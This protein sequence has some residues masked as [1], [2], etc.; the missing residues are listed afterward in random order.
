MNNE[1]MWNIFLGGLSRTAKTHY[2]LRR[3]CSKCDKPIIDVSRFG[4]CRGCKVKERTYKKGESREHK[5]LKLLAKHFLRE[6]GFNEI[7]EEYLIDQKRVDVV[8]ISGDKIIAIE[9]GGS[10]ERKLRHIVGRVDKLYILP[11]GATKPFLWD[12]HSQV[13]QFCGHMI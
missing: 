6:Q 10:L 8:G 5:A 11:Y 1:A 9:C 3:T 7:N 4:L 12:G 2:K 13:C